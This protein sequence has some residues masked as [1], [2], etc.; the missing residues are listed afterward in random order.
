MARPIH[1]ICRL[2]KPLPGAEHCYPRGAGGRPPPDPDTGEP[3]P[4]GTYGR[5]CRCRHCEV[6][7]ITEAVRC[8]CCHGILSRRPRPASVRRH[9]L[10]AA[11]HRWQKEQERQPQPRHPAAQKE[12]A[13][14]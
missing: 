4:T 5:W 1:H 7:L 3:A 12:A 8:P 9:Q 13:C 10:V 2:P 6:W 11:R 14:A